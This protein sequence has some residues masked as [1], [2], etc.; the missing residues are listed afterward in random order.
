MNIG[1]MNHLSY[2][3]VPQG[4]L[5]YAA[6]EN[7]VVEMIVPYGA[8]FVPSGM[9][10]TKMFKYSI[11]FPDHATYCTDQA[12]VVSITDPYT[13]IKYQCDR[14]SQFGKKYCVGRMVPCRKRLIEFVLSYDM[15]CQKFMTNQSN[16]EKCGYTGIV[17]DYD[18]SGRMYSSHY[19]NGATVISK[20]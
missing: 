11:I 6:L 4:T 5:V 16:L 8:M 2:S 9:A 18:V 20:Y 12:Y 14:E 15:A 1:Y 3:P 13:G 17:L 7:T 10:P 19:I